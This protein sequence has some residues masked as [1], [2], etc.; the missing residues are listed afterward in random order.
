MEVP[1]KY[2]LITMKSWNIM[3]YDKNVT[4]VYYCKKIVILNNVLS[5][6]N[7]LNLK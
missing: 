7:S 2:V 1:E 4:L 6:L 3:S 5:D